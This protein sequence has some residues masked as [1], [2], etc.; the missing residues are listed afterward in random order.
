MATMEFAYALPVVFLAMFGLADVVQGGRANLRAQSAAIQVGQ[1]ISQ[2]PQV[3]ANDDAALR[4][5]AKRILD[6]L[7][8]KN[9]PFALRV[10]VFG[11]DGSNNNINWAINQTG[12]T[13][14]A[15]EPA[16]AFSTNGSAVPAGYT[17]GKNQ[18]LIRTEV[19]SS[20]D[21][22]PLQRLVS[23]LNRA[24]AASSPVALGFT[25]ANGTAVHST[26]IPITDGLKAK[27]AASAKGCLT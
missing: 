9:A 2:C 10:T 18:V 20:L 26:R 1:I 22:T 15:G 12:G 21:R 8:V 24:T 25:T 19:L 17:M 11:R 7:N 6:P 4:D 14:R 13:P 3:N 27:G 5:L 23:V 16:L